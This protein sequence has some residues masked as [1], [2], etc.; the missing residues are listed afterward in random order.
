MGTQHISVTGTDNRVTPIHLA[1]IEDNPD[2][3]LSSP[4]YQAKEKPA[5]EVDKTGEP[6]IPPLPV[7]DAKS[8]KDSNS[9]VVLN[10]MS[11]SLFDTVGLKSTT[12]TSGIHSSN[13]LG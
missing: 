8:V 4:I 13:N 3:R 11:I 6:V 7:T 1:E 9:K 5:I 12:I 2:V 10:T